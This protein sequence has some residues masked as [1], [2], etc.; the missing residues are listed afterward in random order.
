MSI[1][2][3]EE[4]CLHS[5]YSQGLIEDRSTESYFSHRPLLRGAISFVAD[6]AA[7][8]CT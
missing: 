5:W 8:G 2:Y 7:R 1:F 3:K 6:G 4:S